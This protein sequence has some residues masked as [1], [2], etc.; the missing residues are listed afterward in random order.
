VHML[1]DIQKAEIIADF[2]LLFLALVLVACYFIHV[3]T[4]VEIK[5]FE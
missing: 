3:K 4:F 2:C 5:K 1:I